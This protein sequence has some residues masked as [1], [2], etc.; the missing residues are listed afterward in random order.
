MAPNATLN[1]YPGGD[2]ALPTTHRD[3]FNADL[4]AF[5]RS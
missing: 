3:A 4:L 5:L 1:V 2:H